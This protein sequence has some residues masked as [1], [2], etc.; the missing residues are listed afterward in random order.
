M[1][2]DTHR[3]AEA[4]WTDNGSFAT[5]GAMDVGDANSSATTAGSVSTTVDAA[6]T[7]TASGGSQASVTTANDATA[8]TD[9]DVADMQSSPTR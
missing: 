9:G 8:T 5:D 2:T 7:A 3:R 1:V 4:G 6:A